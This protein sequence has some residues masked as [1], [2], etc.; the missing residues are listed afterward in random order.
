MDFWI[1]F[2]HGL[3]VLTASACVR[4]MSDSEMS[5]SECDFLNNFCPPVYHS[6]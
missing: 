2:Q 3:S 1:N 6:G 4:E 5:D